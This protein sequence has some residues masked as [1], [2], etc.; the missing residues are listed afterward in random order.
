MSENKEKRKDEFDEA[1]KP[2]YEWLCKYG[3]P[4]MVVVVQQDR[5]DVYEGIEGA[6]LPIVD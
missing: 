5:V 1:V 2:L 6:P 3:H 4:H